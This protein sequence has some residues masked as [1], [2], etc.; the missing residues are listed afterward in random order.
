[1]LVF[2]L[3]AVRYDDIN[4]VDTP[5]LYNL[6]TK[7]I[8]GPMQTI[9]AYDGIGPTLLTGTYPEVHG[10]WTQHLL[11]QEDGPYNWTSS[12]SPFLE[13]VDKSIEE[14]GWLWKGFR[15]ALLKASLFKSKRKFYPGINKIPFRQLAKFDFAMRQ[16][17]YEENA[18]GTLPTLFDLLRE[19]GISYAIV[20]HSFFRNDQN[21]VNKVL[22]IKSPPEVIYVRFMDLDEISHSYGVFSAER[23]N[24]L[25]DLDCALSK[26]VSHFTRMGLHPFVVLFADHGFMNV[27]RNLD[28]M[29]QIK[30]AGI[31]EEDFTMF[32]DS[33]MARFWG[34]NPTIARIS[35]VLADLGCGRV[36]TEGELRHYHI[37]RSSLYGNLIYLVDPGVVILP[38]YYQGDTKVLGMHGYTPDILDMHTLFLVYNSEM[39]SKKVSGTRLVDV[40]PTILDLLEVSKPRNCV[41]VSKLDEQ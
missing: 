4:L 8:F 25:R 31:S 40:L 30:K 41:G 7:G 35:Q 23:R 34:D 33:T 17:L 27:S 3:D 26:I 38:N 13:R 6:T 29:R 22:K 1:M 11:A 5:F 24:G 2:F 21:V 9:L 19:K 16:N 14:F 36:L 12:V 32:L 18:F 37:P 28:V 10:V 39:A 15:F 20:D